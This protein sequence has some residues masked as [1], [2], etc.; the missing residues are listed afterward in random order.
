MPNFIR[1]RNSFTLSL[2]VLFSTISHAQ[3]ILGS[4]IGEVPIPSGKLEFVFK[5]SQDGNQY[6]STLDIPK[7]GLNASKAETTTFSGNEIEMTFP[8]FNISYKGTLNDKDEII[9]NLYKGNN[10]TSLNLRRGTI[11]LNRPQEPKPPFSYHAEDITFHTSDNIQLAGTLTLPNKKGKFPVVII[12]S[13][14]G[15]QDRDG[16]MFG[17]KTYYVLADYLTKNGIGVLRFDERGVGQ[18]EGDFDLATISSL[19][20]DINSAIKYLKTRKDINK[21]KIG[22]IGH[23][24]GGIIAPK[25]AAKNKDVNFIVL[26]AAPAING[27]KLMLLQKSASEKA[28]GL[29][30]LQTFQGRQIVKNAYNII[31]NTTLENQSLKDSIYSFY[32]K[33]YGSLIPEDKRNSLI[34]QVTANEV[35]SLIRSKPSEY[36]EQITCPVLALYGEKDLQVPA[37]ENL[38]A[39]KASFEK[40]GNK[41]VK[42]VELKNL[43]H[44]FQHSKTGMKSEYSQIE[45]TISPEVLDLIAEWISDILKNRKNLK[46]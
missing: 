27:D 10:P 29:S 16:S 30:E 35:L 1:M 20:A 44:L 4:W 7:Q 6:Y 9:G 14:S 41:N 17:H 33:Q 34:Q 23:S 8:S 37:K 19:S 39:L 45:Q 11:V 32:A 38:A 3:N 43:N 46:K 25:V 15:A 26:L 13:G 22:L 24:I 2:F 5:I 12:I 18:S 36:L 31:V 21:K 40:S 42:L 28:M